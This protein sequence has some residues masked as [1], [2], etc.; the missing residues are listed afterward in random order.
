MGLD[1]YVP[2][3][4]YREGK[5]KT[6]PPTQEEL[7]ID[8]DGFLRPVH[9]RDIPYDEIKDDEEFRKIYDELD[10]WKWNACDHKYGNYIDER[11]GNWSTARYFTW[12]VRQF[13]EGSFPLLINLLPANNEGSVPVKD[14]PE[15]LRELAELRKRLPEIKGFFLVDGMKDQ[16]V[17]DGSDYL[18]GNFAWIDKQ[19]LGFDKNGL[20]VLD[21]ETEELLFKAKEVMETVETDDDGK[22]HTLW[23]DVSDSENK[24]VVN[25]DPISKLEDGVV[26]YLKVEIRPMS[27]DDVY[28]IAPL[29]RLF[30]ASIET[31]N[32]VFW[33]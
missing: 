33:A 14:A 29:E 23:T 1:A 18:D 24:I 11:V 5:T 21:R 26:G 19:I 28:A 16:V 2:C 12:V 4:C 10:D 3:N 8:E 30:K 7:C 17:Y 31:G 25:D 22:K 13:P 32:P 6:P 9:Y 15:I 27:A 20:Y